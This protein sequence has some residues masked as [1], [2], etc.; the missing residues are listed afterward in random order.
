MFPFGP[1]EGQVRAATAATYGMIEMIDDGVGRIL[2]RLDELGASDDTIIVFTSDHGDM[3]GDH[4]LMLKAAMHFR[5]C[6]RTPIV[7]ATPG[8]AAA[9][10]TSLAASIDLPHTVLDLCGVPEHQGM[11]GRS[12]VPV[13]DDPSTTV[14]DSGLV[15]E[16]MPGAAVRGGMPL[17]TRTV[18]TDRYRYT[19]DSNG[20]EMLYDLVDDPGELTN[21]AVDGRAPQA[22]TEML[23]ALTDAMI[24]ADDQTRVEPVAG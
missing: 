17:K 8:R 18:V 22:R 3:M 7:V 12:L 5:G 11:Q 9:R 2:R 10:T 13:L 16:D 15:E 23:A 14:R 6:L 1:T 4:G 20:F 19:R 21:L 24:G